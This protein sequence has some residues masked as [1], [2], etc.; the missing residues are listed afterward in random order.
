MA[1]HNEYG[2]WG[3]QVAEEYL[4]HKGYSI[5]ERDW[6]FGH[7]DID[8]IAYEDDTNTLVIVEVKAR[9]SEDYLTALQAVTE[10]KEKNL[11]QAAYAFARYAGHFFPSIRFDVI[12]VV[13]SEDDFKLEHYPG[14]FKPGSTGKRLL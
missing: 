2:A 11:I 8:I 10:Q 1:A 13:G 5:L 4:R 6:H 7:K 9:R 12:T 14:I 3:E